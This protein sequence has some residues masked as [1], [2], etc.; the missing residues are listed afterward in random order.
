MD[1]NSR[2]MLK[3][4]LLGNRYVKGVR[5]LDAYGIIERAITGTQVI[6]DLEIKKDIREQY[7]I[8]KE[9]SRKNCQ[10]ICFAFIGEYYVGLVP[11][12]GES[13]QK[14]GLSNSNG[15]TDLELEE[16]IEHLEPQESSDELEPT[17]EE[18][19]GVI[20]RRKEG[21]PKKDI[22]YQVWGATKGG[23][24]SYKLAEEKYEKIIG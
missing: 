3:V 10:P 16:L 18:R 11:R 22:I 1:S 21:L 23:G 2:S 15:S 7:Y 5:Q 4:V 6:V 12:F 13:G 8:K 9:E 17:L 14:D 19:F 24:K 20:R